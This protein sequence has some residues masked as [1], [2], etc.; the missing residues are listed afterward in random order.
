M[1]QGRNE[2]DST[3]NLKKNDSN[4]VTLYSERADETNIASGN[5][6]RV[7]VVNTSFKR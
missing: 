3:T 5:K 4:L 7:N 6:I 1:K 2:T